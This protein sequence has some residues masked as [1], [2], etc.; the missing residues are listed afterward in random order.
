MSTTTISE[1]DLA[2]LRADA[3][4]VQTLESERDQANARAT[5]AE[6]IARDATNRAAAIEAI[7]ESGHTFTALEKRGLLA[8]LPLAESGEL[9]TA[10]FSTALESAAAES[11]SRAGAA[12]TAAPE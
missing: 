2:T 11:A 4:R 9:D 6:R 3:G 10:A 8:D 12:T 5:E 1:A 7:A